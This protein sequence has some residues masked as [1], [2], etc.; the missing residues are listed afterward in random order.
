MQHGAVASSLAAPDLLHAP[1]LTVT[2]RARVAAIVPALDE[3]GAIGKVL[4]ELTHQEVDAVIVVDNGSTDGT[5]E[6]AR[7]AGAIVVREGRRGYGAACA[8]GVRQAAAIGADVLVF[9]DGDAA[10][11]PACLP[12]VVGPVLRGD[13]DLVL[14]SRVTGRLEAGAIP[15]HQRFGNRIATLLILILYR[16]RLTDIGSFRA[17]RLT[18]VQALQMHHP[19]FGWPVEMVVKSLRRGLR[20]AEVPVDYRCRIGQP[21]VGGTVRGS[22]L[23]GYHMLRTIVRYAR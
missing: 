6:V 1:L 18:H 15:P 7:R 16:R 5:G 3:A 19:T 17:I 23:A 2:A 21:K 14:G 11:D 20:V 12:R 4:G 8:A 13:A 22:L 9:L 10:D